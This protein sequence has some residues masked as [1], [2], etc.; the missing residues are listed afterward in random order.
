[1]KSRE[2]Q[3]RTFPNL[4]S[5]KEITLAREI[6]TEKV[7]EDID[8]DHDPTPPV[9]ECWPQKCGWYTYDVWFGILVGL[10]I[11]KARRNKKD[12][13]LPAD[14]GEI[15]IQLALRIQQVEELRERVRDLE[16]NTAQKEEKA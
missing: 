15:E 8:L 16:M 11:A 6:V 10:Q 13:S 9:M 2:N 14:A 3:I 1:M 12:K 5:A 7:S 4:P